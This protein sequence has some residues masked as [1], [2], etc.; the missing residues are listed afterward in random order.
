MLTM[1][2]I[3]KHTAA[4]GVNAR[5]YRPVFRLAGSTLPVRHMSAAATPADLAD[6]AAA[7][8]LKLKEK[9]LAK[10]Q[11]DDP[12]TSAALLRKRMLYRARQ[13]GWYV[14]VAWS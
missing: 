3:I 13:R 5:A 10:P 8:D 11:G 7:A 14:C 1:I 6:K 4:R 12:A 2:R 9:Y